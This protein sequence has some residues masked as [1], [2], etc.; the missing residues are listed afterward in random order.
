MFSPY[1]TIFESLLCWSGFELKFLFLVSDM[2]G[3]GSYQMDPNSYQ[4]SLSL[5]KGWIDLLDPES[6][7]DFRIRT[8]GSSEESYEDLFDDELS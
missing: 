4:G 2:V 6:Q 7:Q 3:L 8:Y 1:P 5:V